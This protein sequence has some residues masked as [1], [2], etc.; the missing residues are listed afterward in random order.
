MAAIPYPTSTTVLDSLTAAA[1]ASGKK[2]YVIEK[3]F[4]LN[5]LLSA[6]LLTTDLVNLFTL[7]ANTVIMTAA[8]KVIAACV[9]AGGT[10]TLTLRHGTTNVTAAADMLTAGTVAFGGATTTAL[11]A[12]VGAAAVLVNVVCAVGSGTITTNPTIRV[13]L[14]CLDIS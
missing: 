2:P 9:G 12:N 1:P 11:P 13:T 5:T 10:S 6:K 3:T 7:P 4:D 8:L 14:V